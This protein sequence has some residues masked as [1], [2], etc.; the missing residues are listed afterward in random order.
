[1]N[2]ENGHLLS[3]LLRNFFWKVDV[4]NRMHSRKWDKKAIDSAVKAFDMN[5]VDGA[6]EGKL[7]VAPQIEGIDFSTNA[8]SF[9]IFFIYVKLFNKNII[10]SI[11][12]CRSCADSQPA[13]R[14]CI[15]STRFFSSS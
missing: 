4:I 13:S 5:H 2:D 10:I 14:S 15:I 6:S 1:M 8:G 12:I 11:L 9:I 7:T 3:V